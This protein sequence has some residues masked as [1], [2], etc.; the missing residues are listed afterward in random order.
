MLNN[1]KWVQLK[2][3]K[4]IKRRIYKNEV[5]EEQRIQTP[6][7]LIFHT[8][9]R[10]KVAMIGLFLFLTIFICVLV[11]P[12]VCP[13]DKNYQEST[14]QNLSPGR[15]LL[16]VPK[17]V[18]QNPRCI[19]VGPTYSVGVSEDGKVYIWGK[20]K[21]NLRQIPEECEDIVQISA[22]SDHILALKADGSLY[23]WGSNR[24]HQTEIPEE[25][26][27]MKE[28]FQQGG[29]RQSGHDTG[30][31]EA[32]RKQ[33]IRDE[34]NRNEDNETAGDISDIG[35]N[36]TITQILAGN[37]FSCAVTNHGKLYFWGNNNIIGVELFDMQGFIQEIAANN[38][39]IMA[40]L[41][42]GTV[43]MLG[44]KTSAVSN[45]PKEMKH[46][47]SIALSTYQACA[48]L[49]NGEVITWGNDTIGSGQMP[50]F[51][52]SVTKVL[53]G[54]NH[55]TALQMNGEVV[56]WGDNTWKQCKIDSRC[57]KNHIV[58]IYAGSY[59]NY[60]I[61]QEGKVIPWGLRGYLLGTDGFGR[62]VFI[63][64]MAGG[65]LT[66]TIG[67]VAVIIQTILGMIIGGIS[68]YFGG[69]VDNLLMRLAEV[70]NS[71]PFLPFAMILSYLIGTR[72]T[73]GMRILMIMLILGALSW[74][75]MARL[76]RAQVLEIREQEYIFAAKS[77]GIRQNK[78][79][80]QHIL[81]NVASYIIVSA[82]LAFASSML[83]ESA[84]S[85]LGFGVVEPSP[86]WGNMLTGSQSSIIIGTYWWRWLFPALLLSLTTISI[87]LIGDGLRDA[88]DPKS[89]GR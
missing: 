75:G 5:E 34:V 51:D 15:N 47:S 49:E 58:E 19:S 40:L 80:L 78:I 65:K 54:R 23:A 55:F 38:N 31:S 45:I 64:L 1:G 24:F 41:K 50:Q 3:K 22:G 37:Q 62:D 61:T 68:G 12:M 70:V 32:V 8:F 9:F 36:E 89:S 82:T 71:L 42:D 69:K 53:A 74:P 35:E 81:P 18:R 85:F 16:S 73:E 6:Q 56:S 57:K 2:G 88:L 30:T 79:L 59:Q 76:V 39:T 84:L 21:K 17:E 44:R 67:S 60:A 20:Y 48:V 86:T 26:Q 83:T 87:N 72:I 11:I 10:N 77:M 27:R 14:Q 13:F 46:V 7:S 29:D 52:A 63:R 25:I 33:D 66:M 43:A 4:C 28:T